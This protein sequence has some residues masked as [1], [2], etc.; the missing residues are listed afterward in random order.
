MIELQQKPDLFQ[1]GMFELQVMDNDYND[2]ISLMIRSASFFCLL[3]ISLALAS[4][5]IM[6]LAEEYDIKTENVLPL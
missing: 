6:P 4:V 5:T 3:M 2:C 1:T